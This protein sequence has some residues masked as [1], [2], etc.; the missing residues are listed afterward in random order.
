MTNSSA[1]RQLELAKTRKWKAEESEK[2]KQKATTK[3]K[4]SLKRTGKNT[5]T[6][7]MRNASQQR[8][9][10]SIDM[11]NPNPEAGLHRTHKIFYNMKLCS[12]GGIEPLKVL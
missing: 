6:S 10:H 4:S 9:N 8:N 11:T 3:K 2:E 12:K 5:T 1:L 7:N